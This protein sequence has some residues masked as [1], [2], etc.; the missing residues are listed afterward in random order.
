MRT[1]I[2]NK[3]SQKCPKAPLR[4]SVSIYNY[5]SYAAR[6]TPP[7]KMVGINVLCAYEVIPLFTHTLTIFIKPFPRIK[8][9]VII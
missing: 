8:L 9:F 6:N 1:Y 3:A 7:P 2:Y 5:A 4:G